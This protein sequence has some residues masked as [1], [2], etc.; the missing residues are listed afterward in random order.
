MG[1]WA[2]RIVRSLFGSGENRKI[3]IVG[4]NNAGKTTILY[5][6]HL[7]QVILTQPTI[8]SNVEE[9]K[10]SN[11]TF[12]VWDLGGQEKLRAGW[13][14]YFQDTDAVIFVVDSN[15]QENMVLAKMELFNVVLQEDLKH[16]C[17]LVL[18]NKQD[19][20]GCKTAAEIAQDLSLQ[21]LRTHE[22]QIQSCCALTGEGLQEGL[23]WIATRIRARQANAAASAPV[24][25][26][27]ATVAASSSAP[28]PM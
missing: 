14:T 13:A 24:V 15:D 25:A 21:T 2:S 9:V 19:I 4:L 23:E 22:W 10:H 6:L 1:I 3:V 28:P 8:G 27:A 5:K 20:A 17:L 7:G 26:A 12:Q 11:I 16:A 18:A